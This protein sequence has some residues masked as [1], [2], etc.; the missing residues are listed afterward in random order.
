[1]TQRSIA[2]TTIS[3]GILSIPVKCYNCA[4][5]EKYSF[6]WISPAGNPVG[7]KLYDKKTG[8]ELQ[9]AEVQNAVEVEEGKYVVFED[10]D[11]DEI[12]GEKAGIIEVKEVVRMDRLDSALVPEKQMWLAPD[13]KADK[14]YRLLARCLDEEESMIIGVWHHR[15][16][17]HLVAIGSNGGMLTMLQLYRANELRSVE[18]KFA[19]DTEPSDEEAALGCKLLRKMMRRGKFELGDY[20]SQFG[21][22]VV[23]LAAEKYEALKKGE[24]RSK[25]TRT[26]ALERSEGDLVDVLERSLDEGKKVG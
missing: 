3:M 2:N 12:A 17:D 25:Y 22:R 1:M 21:D 13:K 7:T 23:Q 16:K 4:V 19:K 20:K 9:R 24:K 26:Q 15:N 14:Q 6:V 5:E 10:D 11:M 18:V 8:D